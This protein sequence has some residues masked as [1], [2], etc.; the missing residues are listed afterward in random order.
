METFY[1]I[2]EDG[3]LYIG[4][5]KTIPDGYKTDFTKIETKEDG[6][7]ATWYNDNGT[8]NVAKENEMFVAN[9]VTTYKRY[10]LGVV[11]AKLKELDYDSIATVNL[12]K[13]DATFGTEATAILTW[14]RSIIDVNYDILNNI[15]NGTKY[16]VDWADIIPTKEEYLSVLPEYVGA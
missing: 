5:G 9:I 10:Y 12:W 16:I 14:Y 15:E 11:N 4:S 1:R 13:D 3:R 2:N 8:I 6:S 7:Y